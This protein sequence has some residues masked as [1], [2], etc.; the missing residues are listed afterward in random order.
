MASRLDLAGVINNDLSFTFPVTSGGK[1][2]NL[3]GYTVTLVVKASQTATDGSG[4]TYT[5]GSGLT[6]LSTVAGRVQLAIPH[7]ATAIAGVTWYRLDVTTGGAVSTA[8][9]GS[10]T[11][12]SA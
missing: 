7:T 6:V 8:F 5:V 10:L 9:V 12:M 11:L 4:T 3:T 2:L 1:P